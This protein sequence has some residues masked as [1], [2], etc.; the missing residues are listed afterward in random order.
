MPE[1]LDFLT[2][3]YAYVAIGEFKPGR[4]SEAQQLYEKAVSTY[5]TGFKGAFL[6][7][8]PGTDTGI[9]VIMWENLE[10]METNQTEAYNRIMQEMAHLFVKPPATDFYE[11]CSEIQP[12]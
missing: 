11:I 7:Q 9:A 6:L 1:F 10:D 2:H 5:T 3:K 8:K 4:F 12:V